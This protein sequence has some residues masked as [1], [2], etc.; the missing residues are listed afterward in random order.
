MRGFNS[1]LF[2]LALTNQVATRRD[3]DEGCKSKYVVVFSVDGLHN[4]DPD[5]WLARGP[6]NISALLKT[7]Y[8]TFYAPS[9]GCEGAP[10]AEVVYDESI[11]YNSTE[12]FSGGIN[13]ANLSQAIINGQCT[14]IY[15][16]MRTG[17]NTAFE[18]VV[19]A[20][21]KTAYTDKHPAYDLMRPNR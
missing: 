19:G 9:S 18:V 10:G 12:L 6:S 17:V 5:K 8:R 7:G 15:P 20:G 3:D 1:I 4:S 14:N 2:S 21:Y 13:P 11:D 16:H